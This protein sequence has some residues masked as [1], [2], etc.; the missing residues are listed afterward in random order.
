MVQK[1][2]CEDMALENSTGR[3]GGALREK[4]KR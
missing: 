4:K 1:P 2:F 3:G